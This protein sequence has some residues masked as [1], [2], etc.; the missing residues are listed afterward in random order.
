MVECVK[1]SIVDIIVSCKNW[2]LV[3]W[4]W[5]FG[6]S[7]AHLIA[8]VK[9]QMNVEVKLTEVCQNAMDGNW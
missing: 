9:Q 3:C 6:W 8:A 4:W 1:G 7:I 5:H 2:V